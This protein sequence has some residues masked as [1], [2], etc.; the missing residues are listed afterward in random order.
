L[1]PL[2]AAFFFDSFESQGRVRFAHRGRSGSAASLTPDELIETRADT[3][4]YEMTRAQESDL[5]HAAKVTFIDG[6]RDYEQG[7]AEGRRI[8]GNAARVAAARLPVV[9][10]YTQAR[11]IAETMV[12]EAHANR[13]RGNFS[14]PP[15][16][17][18]LDPSDLVTLAANGRSFPLRLTGLSVG[19]AIDAEALSIEPQLY[20]PFAAPARQPVANAPDIYG[21]QL[22]IFLDLPLIRGDEVPFAG[23][24]AAFGNP[25][26]GGVAFYRSPTTSGYTLK[27]LAATRAVLGLTDAP[28]HSGPTS[29]WDNGNTLRV[30]LSAGELASA[31]DLLVLGGANICAIQN[32][33]GDWEVIQFA[34][35]T[36]VAPL[37]YELTGLLRGQ[38]GTE[39]AMRDPVDSGA[40]F[41][42]LDSSVI[43]VD[44]TQADIG[45]AFNWT[46]GPS[47][48][49]I[50][51]AAYLSVTE[52]FIGVGLRP[53]SPIHITAEQVAEGLQM[54]WIRRTRIGGDGWEQTEVPLG[55]DGETYEIEILDGATVKRTL[56]A[57]APSVIYTVAQQTTDF[58]SPQPS[59]TIRVY[60]FSASYGRGAA[61]EAVV[62]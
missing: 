39:A 59:Y 36:L 12:Q 21:A 24:V 4:L 22:G 33:D 62:P 9:T 32:A 23:S 15:S 13:E 55:E 58:G 53:L 16:R 2:E 57:S 14:L 35:A 25:W 49:D 41:V 28:F 18:A 6:E 60:Q 30:V 7:M 26:P 42:L 8:S 3:P 38:A 44:M 34:T 50:G 48:Y 51:N 47:V 10:S 31:E 27:A 17:L 1:Q 37:T 61:R 43:Q 11:G 54:S 45:L 5:P 46:Y 40:R 20:D 19:E 52:A 29:R 56:S